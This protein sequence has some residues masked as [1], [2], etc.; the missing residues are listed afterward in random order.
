MWDIKET[1]PATEL[2]HGH[3]VVGL[4]PVP[5]TTLSFR[6]VRGV[7]LRTPGPGDVTPNTA[8]IY[9]GRQG[10]TADYDP[11]TGGMPLPPGSVLELAV[12]DPSQVFAVST[13]ENQDLAWMGV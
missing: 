9:V 7:R 3:T 10:V 11:G 6:F 2:K 5:L 4:A 8:V 1:S 12:D 13:G